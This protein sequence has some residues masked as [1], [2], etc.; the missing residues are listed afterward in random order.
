MLGALLF[1]SLLPLRYLVSTVFFSYSFSCFFRE[2]VSLL[3][4]NGPGTPP[5]SSLSAIFTSV[6][7]N[8][9]KTIPNIPRTYLDFPNHSHVFH[10]LRVRSRP[11][12]FSISPFPVSLSRHF[13]PFSGIFFSCPDTF[14]FD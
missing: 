9:L 1:P 14:F 5:P 6:T 11:S 4:P 8:P 2:D 3:T 7:L 13:P 10:M 12:P